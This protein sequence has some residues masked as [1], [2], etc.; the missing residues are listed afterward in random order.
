MFSLHPLIDRSGS[1]GPWPLLALFMGASFL[2]IWRLEHMTETGVEGTVLGTLVMPYCSGIGNLIFVFVVYSKGQPA[3]EVMT[4]CLV[5]NV[6]NM[7]LL[8]GLPAIFW[9]LRVVPKPDA[10]RKKQSRNNQREQTRRINRLSLLL[11]LTA[12][13]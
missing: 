3:A 9:G 7:T 13:L 5:N 2:M 1:F 12:V 6:T 4:N 11:T 8:I 10:K